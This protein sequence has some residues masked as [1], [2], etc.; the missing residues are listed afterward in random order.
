MKKLSKSFEKNPLL[1]AVGAV[2]VVLALWI[3]WGFLSPMVKP[4]AAYEQIYCSKFEGDPDACGNAY[5]YCVIDWDPDDARDPNVITGIE[6]VGCADIESVIDLGI[7]GPDED[8]CEWVN[9]RERVRI[10]DYVRGRTALG[11]NT[12]EVLAQPDPHLCSAARSINGFKICRA[13]K[14]STRASVQFPINQYLVSVPELDPFMVKD[15]YMCLEYFEASPPNAG[16]YEV[17]KWM[18][19]NQDPYILPIGEEF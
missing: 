18:E 17:N 19:D 2:V 14:H 16:Y 6:N 11:W 15:R 12:R 9:E 1:V 3:L 4:Q 7:A 13:Y 10:I 5:P 8:Y